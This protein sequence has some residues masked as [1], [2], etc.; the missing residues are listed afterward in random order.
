LTGSL[1]V[2]GFRPAQYDKTIL[3]TLVLEDPHIKELIRSL[4]NK[5]LLGLRAEAAREA[6]FNEK[7]K[8]SD[9]VE[10]NTAWS[11]DFVKG[12]GEGLIFLLHGKPGVGKTY[13][14]GESPVISVNLLHAEFV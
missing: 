11:P 3:D 10:H 9:S 13:T 5:Y 8:K 7:N 1:E 2:S 14:A 6:N 12:K 4:T